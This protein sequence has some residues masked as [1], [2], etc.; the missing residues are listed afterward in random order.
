MVYLDVKNIDI[1]KKC[2]I[3]MVQQEDIALHHVP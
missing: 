1:S 3:Q 2:Y